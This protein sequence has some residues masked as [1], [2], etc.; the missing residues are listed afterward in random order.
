M[1]LDFVSKVPGNDN[2][3]LSERLGLEFP[4]DWCDSKMPIEKIVRL[5]LDLQRFEDLCR[6]AFY[7]GIERLLTEAAAQYGEDRGLWPGR[8][9][10]ML[11]NIHLVMINQRRK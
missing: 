1:A 6:L 4:Y 3:R 5:A 2:Q 7:V 10:D 9:S 8:L 11:N